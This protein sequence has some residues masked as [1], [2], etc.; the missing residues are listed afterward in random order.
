MTKNEQERRCKSCGKLLI[1]E[2]TIWCRRCIL[3]GRNKGAKVGGIVLGV[4]TTVASA[5]A[6]GNNKS[7]GDA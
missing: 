3:E 1:D 5:I 4:V 6:L 2:K 7:S